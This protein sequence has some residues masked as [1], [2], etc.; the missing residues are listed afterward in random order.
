[1]RKKRKRALS[2]ESIMKNLA[3]CNREEQNQSICCQHL[4]R[5]HLGYVMA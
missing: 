5:G 1:M 2:S 4:C 3:I